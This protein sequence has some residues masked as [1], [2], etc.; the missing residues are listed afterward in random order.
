[1][2]LEAN[3]ALGGLGVGNGRRP[4]R[5]DARFPGRLGEGLA[6]ARQRAAE[7]VIVDARGP[8]FDERLATDGEIHIAGR[9]AAEGGVVA[10]ARGVGPIDGLL[11]GD[12][13]G[14]LGGQARGL[15]L[16]GDFLHA[17]AH[18]AGRGGLQ[19]CFLGDVFHGENVR[20]GL[21][22]HGVGRN[23]GS[24][25]VLGG[26][27]SETEGGRPHVVRTGGR[28]TSIKEA[29]GQHRQHAERNHRQHD[30]FAMTLFAPCDHSFPF[31]TARN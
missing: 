21:V 8:F 15:F 4:A 12:A 11:L 6:V 18:I 19:R 27:T 17:G 24:A 16:V 29:H 25:G 7:Q 3:A 30:G 14:F 1:M 5:V 23:I 13:S 31:S 9:Q 26:L 28:P 20:V 22:L 10:G 2:G